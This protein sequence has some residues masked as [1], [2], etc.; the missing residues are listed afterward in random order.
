MSVA[1]LFAYLDRSDEGLSTNVMKC[2]V[3][4]CSDYHVRYSRAGTCCIHCPGLGAATNQNH[5]YPESGLHGDTDYVAAGGTPISGD[6][7]L[8]VQGPVQW[9]QSNTHFALIGALRGYSVMAEDS[10]QPVQ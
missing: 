2:E 7:V 3:P 6:Q 1:G 9:P 4:T 8:L 10:S 5:G